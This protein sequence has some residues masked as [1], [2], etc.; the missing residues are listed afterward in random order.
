MIT[1]IQAQLRR[2]PLPCRWFAKGTG[3]VLA[4]IT[5][6][7]MAIL[8]S[9]LFA[10][11][12]WGQRTVALRGTVEDATGEYVLGADVR[13]LN[14]TTGQQLSTSS[15]EEGQFRFDHVAF[16]D[17]MLIVNAQGF[18]P[19]DVP[20]KA[21][22]SAESPIRVRLQ[23]AASVESV[24]VSAN[25]ASMPV[26]GQNVDV[27]EL[28]R[29]WL[30]N[31]PSKEGDPLAVPSIFL[32][33][34][35]AG[36][37]GPKIIVDGV[38]S[39]ALEVPLTSIRRVYVNKSPY[40]AEFGRP[41]RG[42][43]EV[44]T[45]KGSRRDYHGNLTLLLRDSA[46]DAR[47]AFSR[48][49][50]PLQREIAETELD[51]PLGN[52]VRFLLAGRYYTSDESATVH[53]AGPTGP[54]IENVPT[55]QHNTRLFGRLDFDLTPKHTLTVGYKFKSN[56]QQNQGVGAFNFAERATDLSI[57][58]N[59][60]KVFERAFL[61]PTFLNE[62][63]FAFKDE[64]QQTTSV[65][66][67]PANIV[68]G[69]FSS[70]GAQ[71]SL[72]QQERAF[73][74][75]DAAT[76]IKG[77]HTLRFGAGARPRSFQFTDASNFGGTFTFASLAAFNSGQPEVFA[78]NQ[79]NPRISFTQ[80]EYYSFFQD[81]IQVR[82]DLSVFLGLRHE[83]QSNLSDHNNFAPRVAFAFSP[84]GGQM[85]LRGGFGIFY[86]RQP[87]I[88]REQTLL[89]D[90]AQGYQI[91]VENPGYPV[92]YNPTSPPPPSLLRIASDI[93]TPYLTQ[94][95]LGIERKL[96][97]G[98]NFLAIDYTVVRG[99]K[100]YRTRNINAP[101]PGTESRPDPAFVDINQFESSG[102]SRSHSLTVSLQTTLRSRFDLLGQYTFSTSGMFSLPAN[103]SDLRPEYGRADYDRRHRFN[104]ISI[105]HL[106]WDFRAGTILSMNS[107]IPYNITTGFD[108]NGDTVPNDRPFGIGRNTGAGPGYASVD[109]HLSKRITFTKNESKDAGTRPAAR[110]PSGRL[111]NLGEGRREGHGPWLEVGVDAFNVFNRTNFKNFVG[112][113]TSPF[114]GSANAANPPRQVQF[115]MKFHF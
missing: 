83:W 45:K 60:V 18:K 20:V 46:L 94:A 43:I 106:P 64:P 96:G 8:F 16:G 101:L 3:R 65:S 76:L 35:A 97:R 66:D 84:H 50:P 53:A 92:P 68:L 49:R 34:S 70:G 69:A 79:G 55:P 30:E 6:M 5:S 82:Q 31:L 63:H 71:I 105:Y 98:K 40:S 113:Q 57:H 44:I 100:L 80:N 42:R 14:Q 87:E 86:D 2:V 7:V 75:Q 67:Q 9:C 99:L 110:S 93:R 107:G 38:E 74:I 37:L 27:V 85:V 104:L 58:E 73:T 17:Y 29:H 112:V 54:V 23:I 111:S 10:S 115:S 95:S 56:S 24:T 39:S 32:D 48:V 41:G 33:P 36:A 90:G 26:A 19:E 108:N 62:L 28:D 21:G 52:K 72:R 88:M 61:S 102:R 13:L 22:E 89:H 11:A 109:F 78:M 47:N 25:N 91:V 103:N 4:K 12:A 77:K 51:G 114:F 81:E 15:D 59:E 1:S